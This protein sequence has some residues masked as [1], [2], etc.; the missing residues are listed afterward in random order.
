MKVSLGPALRF[1]EIHNL[2]KE[3][4]KIK[5]DI[6]IGLPI[7]LDISL[8][9][10]KL[11]N[12]VALEKNLD[13][14]FIIKKHPAQNRNDLNLFKKNISKEIHNKISFSNQSFYKHYN[15]TAC[16]I[17]VN[18]T[19]CVEAAVVGLPII[20]IGNLSGH[21]DNPLVDLIDENR[22]KVCFTSDK[23][24]DALNNLT[25]YEKLDIN[26]YFNPPSRNNLL[27]LLNN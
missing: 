20:I 18:S 12:K 19:L 7:F 21:T 4:N 16:L 26:Q 25:N 17:S 23:V 13:F 11:I 5:K 15:T 10:I 24:I 9:I 22:W 27:Q 2:I 14:N 6:F 1:S 8:K 3:P